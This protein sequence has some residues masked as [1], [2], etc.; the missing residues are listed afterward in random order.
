M[1]NVPHLIQINFYQNLRRAILCPGFPFPKLFEVFSP[2]SRLFVTG[3][4]CSCK[5]RLTYPAGS[6]TF[7]FFTLWIYCWSKL[8][9]FFADCTALS[10]HY[11]TTLRF[12]FRSWIT[13]IMNWN[14]SYRFL[15]QRY[16]RTV[17]S[18]LST[19][20]LPRS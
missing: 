18:P 11:R 15:K 4:F 17:V 7:Y 16:C 5:T 13:R 9:V 10:R 3:V 6:G 20:F 2:I 12:R 8:V 14:I 19:S 1:A